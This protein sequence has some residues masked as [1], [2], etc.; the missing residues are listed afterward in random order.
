MICD[1]SLGEITILWYW[2]KRQ[3]RLDIINNEIANI[4]WVCDTISQAISTA[5]L[6]AGKKVDDVIINPFFSNTFFFSKKISHKRRDPSINTNKAEITYLID[7]TQRIATHSLLSEL[8]N[9]F[10]LKSQDIELILNS[11]SYMSI[12]GNKHTS[13]QNR[14]WED[15][16]IELLN[17][18]IP[19]NN[20]KI[21][22][23][24]IWYLGKNILHIIPE[25]YSLTKIDSTNKEMVFLN[26]G[27]TNT[28]LSIKD[29]NNLLL[30]S[31][32]IETGIDDLIKIIAKRSKKDRSEIIKKL[33][34][35]DLFKEEKNNFLSIFT[36]LLLSGLRE[37]VWHRVC[38]HTFTLSGWWANNDFLR[39]H[40]LKIDFSKEKIKVL[41]PLEIVTPD[42]NNIKSIGWVEKI[43]SPSTIA[44][45]SQVVVTNTLLKKR[46]IS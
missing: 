27:N 44:I 46:I 14:S 34:R 32:K 12:N 41:K 3:S 40:L 6:E 28:L 18:Y 1:F 22:S 29:S 13:L 19:K 26:I 33:D 10:G 25:E 23:D 39:E 45:L 37:I 24:V 4:S 42:I 8:S 5:E 9:K 16:T 38:P 30:G 17:C 7:K 11:I 35:D 2:E 36:E 20:S 15:I 21:I 31:I 43:L